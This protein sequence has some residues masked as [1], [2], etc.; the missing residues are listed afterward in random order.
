M[1]NNFTVIWRDVEIGDFE[2]TI[3]DMWYLEGDCKPNSTSEAQAFT[4]LVNKFNAI[5]VMKDWR[6]G[7]RVLLK[8]K[9]KNDVLTHALIISL[10]ENKLL[11]RRVFKKEAIEQL[12]KNVKM[13]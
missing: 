2:N 11:L 6:H 3:P 8:S 9:E 12:L 1:N 10:N 4:N 7:T 5:F 13:I